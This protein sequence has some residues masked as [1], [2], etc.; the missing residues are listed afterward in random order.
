M[1]SALS[2]RRSRYHGA[3][4]AA[5][6]AETNEAGLLRTYVMGSL[7][8]SCLGGD[9]E[10]RAAGTWVLRSLRIRRDDRPLGDHGQCAL[11]G[12]LLEEMF[13]DAVFERME[14]DD[15]D[16][17]TGLER[18]HQRGQRRFEIP[19]LVVRGDA[20]RLEGPGREMQLAAAVPL[21][22]RVRDDVDEREGRQDAFAASRLHD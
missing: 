12:P 6:L 4:A 16:A 19:E 9:A 8:R 7:V 5:A 17:A 3:Y 20:K 2:T 13:D 11:G 10:L 22:H 21:G 18:A 1:S 15:G 14:R